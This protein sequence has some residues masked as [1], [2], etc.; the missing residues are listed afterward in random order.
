MAK[1]TIAGSG[2]FGTA[3]AIMA[4]QNGHRVTLWSAFQPEI[5]EITRAKKI[6]GW[7]RAVKRAY[8]WARED[9]E[10]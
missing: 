5:D 1:I 3:L 7:Q 6:R 8:G 2:G 10:A 9:E 4:A